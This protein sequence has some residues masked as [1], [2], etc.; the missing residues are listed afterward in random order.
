MEHVRLL[1]DGPVAGTSSSSR[2]V[3]Q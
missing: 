1:I 3:R 2:M